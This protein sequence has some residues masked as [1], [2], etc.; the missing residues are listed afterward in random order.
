[1]THPNALTPWVPGK[2][3]I[4][5]GD[6]ELG[7]YNLRCRNEDMPPGVQVE[8]ARFLALCSAAAVDDIIER[9]VISE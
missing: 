8:R 4:T 6:F 3:L 5:P 9:L 1:M 2:Y 7:M